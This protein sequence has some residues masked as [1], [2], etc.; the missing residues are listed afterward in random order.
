MPANTRADIPTALRQ[1]HQRAAK[2]VIQRELPSEGRAPAAGAGAGARLGNPPTRST[3]V[4]AARAFALDDLPGPRAAPQGAQHRCLEL[5]HAQAGRG[6]ARR[7][8]GRRRGRARWVQERARVRGER[9][10][11]GAERLY[12]RVVDREGALADRRRRVELG[13]GGDQREDFDVCRLGAEEVGDRLEGEVGDGGE[14]ERAEPWLCGHRCE[15]VGR[16]GVARDIEVGDL[17]S[18]E[19]GCLSDD[20]QQVLFRQREAAGHIAE[21]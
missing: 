19:H 11:H 3:D 6:L 9:E 12:E 10:G 2:L 5:E 16:D 13:R 4:P 17:P 7:E 14:T 21:E 18:V 1:P 8:R 15:D 20:L